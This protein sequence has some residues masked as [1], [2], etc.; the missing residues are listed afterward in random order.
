MLR[1]RLG[2]GRDAIAD[3]VSRK[4]PAS[5]PE[6]ILPLRSRMTIPSRSRSWISRL[7]WLFSSPAY[8]MEHAQL[9]GVPAKAKSLTFYVRDIQYKCKWRRRYYR[10]GRIRREP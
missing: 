1:M 9:Y 10:M 5:G 2:S 8:R 6:V 4:D 3:A 7:I